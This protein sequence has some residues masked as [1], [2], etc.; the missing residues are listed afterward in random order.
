MPFGRAPGSLML[1]EAFKGGDRQLRRVRDGIPR[2]FLGPAAERR[3]Q[4]LMRKALMAPSDEVG[5]IGPSA[6]GIDA[7]QMPRSESQ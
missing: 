2:V 7:A 5:T 6:A 3:M 4:A 1:L